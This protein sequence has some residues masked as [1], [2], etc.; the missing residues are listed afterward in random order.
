M[1]EGHV[2]TNLLKSKPPDD[3][4]KEMEELLNKMGV[5]KQLY[6]DQEGTFTTEELIESMSVRKC[7]QIMVIDGARTI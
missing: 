3:V 4:V 5:P 7:V 2:S 6:S 1:R